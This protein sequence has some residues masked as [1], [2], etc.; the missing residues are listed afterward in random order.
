VNRRGRASATAPAI[1]LLGLALFA[2][3]GPSAL[4]RDA[5]TPPKRSP[6]AVGKLVAQALGAQVAVYK[7]PGDASPASMLANP[8][9]TDGQLLFLVDKVRTDGWLKVL[10]PL[11]PN[12]S[13]GWILTSSVGL[14]WNPYRIEVQLG[15]HE[16][17]LL[18]G[19]KK[20][21][22][23][24]PVGIGKGTTPTPGGRYYVTQLFQP[25]DPTGPYG[26]FAFALS[27][28]SEVLTTFKGGDAIVGI[29]GTN[30]PELVGQDVSS[31]CI[32]MTNDAI[33]RLA[34]LLPLGTPVTIRK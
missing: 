33:K 14:G 21:V 18:K 31:G 30:H 17:T 16:L 4:A 19:A 1:A 5:A 11:R 3:T 32:R 13:T 27:G 24:E 29:H 12:G 22:L 8:T 25:P 10:L 26:P 20:V 15:A 6:H 7:A 2:L 28:F 23:R 9:A 34:K